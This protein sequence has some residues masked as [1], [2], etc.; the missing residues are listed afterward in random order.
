MRHRCNADPNYVERGITVCERCDNYLLF[1]Q[2]MGERP[3]GMT[4]ER[5][6]NDGNYC[7]ENCI[8][9]DRTTQAR[10]KRAPR[11]IKRAGTN[12]PMRYISKRGNS[13]VLSICL[14]KGHRYSRSFPTLEQ[15][16]EERANC[17][18][19]RELHHRLGGS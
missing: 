9:A 17:E 4:I 10:N 13:Y 16:L 15:A 1:L 14:R 3:D 19:E 11:F 2:D 6:D 7:P 8:W 18:M 12:V 5:V